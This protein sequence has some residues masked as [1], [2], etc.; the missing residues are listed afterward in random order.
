[1]NQKGIFCLTVP[2]SLHYMCTNTLLCKVK[3]NNPL[4]H[5]YKIFF[6]NL[7]KRQQN[8]ISQEVFRIGNVQDVFLQGQERL[9]CHW[10]SFT[11]RCSSLHHFSSQMTSA[12]SKRWRSHVLTTTTLFTKLANEWLAAWL[13]IVTNSLV[14]H[15]V[16]KSPPVYFSNNFVKSRLI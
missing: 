14:A 7:L 9:H 15:F 1:M 5:E 11:T 8:K 16:S 12:F 13:D 4:R 6:I 3:K 10:S 2:N